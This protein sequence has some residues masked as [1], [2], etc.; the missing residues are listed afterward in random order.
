METGILQYKG[1]VNFAFCP[2]INPQLESMAENPDKVEVVHRVCAIIDSEIHRNYRIYPVNYIA[3]DRVEGG[4]RFASE[5]SP[6]E[7]EA[8]NSYI[9]SQLDKVDL[10]DVS[11]EEREFMRDQIMRMYANPLRNKLAA[12]HPSHI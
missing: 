5:Y 8:F 10:P 6:A 1:R 4:S 9:E 11:A 3:F 7:V 2:C 12:L